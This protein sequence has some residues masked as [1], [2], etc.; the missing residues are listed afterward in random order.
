MII[1]SRPERPWPPEEDLPSTSGQWWDRT[2]CLLMAVFSVGSVI[3]TA[4]AVAWMFDWVVT[5]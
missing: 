5:Q 1:Y 3:A 4:W 2:A